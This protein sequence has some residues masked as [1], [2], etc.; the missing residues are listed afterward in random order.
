MATRARPRSPATVKR[1]T[2]QLFRGS[3]R[4]GVGTGRGG[5]DDTSVAGVPGVSTTGSGTFNS[6]DTSPLR[7]RTPRRLRQREALHP[8]PERPASPGPARRRAV[9]LRPPPPPIRAEGEARST[10]FPI[11]PKSTPRTAAGFVVMNKTFQWDFS[12]APILLS[13]LYF[14]V[15]AFTI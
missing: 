4:R 2:G 13:D 9:P 5:I 10:S 6:P 7:L 15:G 11:S 12:N 3:V 8:P 1:S 14:Q